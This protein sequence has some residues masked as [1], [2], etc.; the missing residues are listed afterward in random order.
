MM[1][2]VIQE[3]DQGQTPGMAGGNQK[4]NDGENAPK[5]QQADWTPLFLFLRCRFVNALA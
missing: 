4:T 5:R 1:T 3:R 2:V